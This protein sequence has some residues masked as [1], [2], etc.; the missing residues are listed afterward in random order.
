MFT[1]IVTETGTV[2]EMKRDKGARLVLSVPFDTA[3][4]AIGASISLA[5]ACFTV[6]EKGNDWLSF[7]VS[8]ETLS[9]TTLGGWKE[10]DEVNIERPLKVGD[11]LGGH[12]V[13]GHVDGVAEVLEQS[14]M[15]GT[16]E[17]TFSLP[18]HV[19]HLVAEKGS[20]AVNGVSLTLNSVTRDTFRVSI[21]PHTVAETT[22]KTLKKGDKVNLEADIFARYSAR[23]HEMKEKV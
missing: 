4:V 22:F 2:R 8:G 13:L 10:G 5:G 6:K 7:D 11:E 3:Q 18:A 23:Q 19:A 14:V 16:K 15:E 21:I 20:I 12:L 9:R 1:G 17:F